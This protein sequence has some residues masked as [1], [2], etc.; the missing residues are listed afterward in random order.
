MQRSKRSQ[1]SHSKTDTLKKLKPETRSRSELS[2][3]N[4]E[5]KCVES[6]SMASDAS[7]QTKSNFDFRDVNGK[8]AKSQTPNKPQIESTKA[9]PNIVQD[10]VLM[11][12]LVRIDSDDL[13]KVNAE[14]S[15]KV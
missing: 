11:V 9:S 5:A 4:L 2:K 8:I 13:K 7:N 12:S 14:E 15:L 6:D 10:R 1:V 3:K